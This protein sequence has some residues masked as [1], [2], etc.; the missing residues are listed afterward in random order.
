MPSL[1]IGPFSYLL[2]DIDTGIGEASKLMALVIRV[3]GCLRSVW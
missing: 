3:E 1:S 2:E